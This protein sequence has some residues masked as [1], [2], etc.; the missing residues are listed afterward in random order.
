MVDSEHPLVALL[1]LRAERRRRHHHL[2]SAFG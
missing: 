1:H 2:N